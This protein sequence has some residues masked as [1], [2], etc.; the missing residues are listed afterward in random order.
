MLRPF[1]S[2]FT[3]QHADNG[4]LDAWRGASAW[5]RRDDLQQASLSRAQYDECGPDY[6]A[7]HCASNVH[8]LPEE[9]NP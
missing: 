5:S 1:G 6:L 3:V 2:A 7:E 8:V 9:A 4:R